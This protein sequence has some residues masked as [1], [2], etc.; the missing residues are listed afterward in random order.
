MIVDE[1][2]QVIP[3]HGPMATK[4]DL[5]EYLN[6]LN[7]IKTRVYA[8]IA[9]GKGI[10]ELDLKAI[11]RGY[12]ELAGSFINEERLSQIFYNSLTKD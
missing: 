1:D 11:V 7:T 8:E 12:E 5:A 4:A 2:T 9:A 6:F 10:R 3:G